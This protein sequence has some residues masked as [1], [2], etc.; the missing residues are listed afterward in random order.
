[1][2]MTERLLAAWRDAEAAVAA[3]DEGTTEWQ[4]ARLASENA[5]AAYRMHIDGLLDVSGHGLTADR[6]TPEAADDEPAPTGEP[7]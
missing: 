3:S 4:R 5:S 6:E 1:M 7:R 2:G